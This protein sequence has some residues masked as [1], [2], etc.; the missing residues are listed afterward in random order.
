[1]APNDSLLPLRPYESASG[2]NP[3]SVLESASVATTSAV[4]HEHGLID[5]VIDFAKAHPLS[6]ALIGTG[7]AVATVGLGRTFLL[8]EKAGAALS[9]GENLVHLTNPAAAEAIGTCERIGGRYGIFAVKADQLPVSP[10]G[11]FLNTLVPRDLTAE[12]QITGDATRAFRAPDPV[13]PFSFLRR[14]GGVRSSPLGSVDLA[15]NK[16]VADEIFK[17][18]AFRAATPAEQL[19]YKTHQYMLDYLIDAEIYVGLGTVGYGLTKD[20]KRGKR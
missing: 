18:G 20:W 10:V 5:E 12:V 14:L 3:F 17:D 19:I 9:E 16:F 11:R 13:G 1:M 8:E 15:T 4:P 7:L 6:A 2:Q